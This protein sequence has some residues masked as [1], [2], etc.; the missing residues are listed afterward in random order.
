MESLAPEPDSTYL[1]LRKRVL[2]LKPDEVGLSPSP[3]Y[4]DVWGVMMEIGYEVGSASLV[5][6]SD[7]T[8]SLYYSTGGGMLGSPDYAPVAKAAKA[9]VAQAERLH[10]QMTK[11]EEIALPSAGRV[12]FTLLTF[13]GILTAETA[14]HSLAS[15]D[16]ALSPLYASGRETLNQLRQLNDKKRA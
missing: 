7:G 16:H 1:L 11:S 4:G 8:T 14:E 3:A 5:V 10:Q 2:D 9:M 6:L 12:R 13:S 15:E